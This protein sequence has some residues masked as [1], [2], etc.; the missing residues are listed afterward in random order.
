MNTITEFAVCEMP[1]IQ[2]L[3]FKSRS[4]V[5]ICGFRILGCF[6]WPMV[7]RDVI[8]GGQIFKIS[9]KKNAHRLSSDLEVSVMN[10][11]VSNTSRTEDSNFS[12]F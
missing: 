10:F 3:G 7:L 2:H 9:K 12:P 6:F 4:G 11:H 1:C 5:L 8:I